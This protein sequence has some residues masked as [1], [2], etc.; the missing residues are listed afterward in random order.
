LR[1]QTIM[2]VRTLLLEN[3][4]HAF[5]AF[6][7][8]TLQTKV[9]LEWVLRLLFERSGTQMETA[10]QVVYWVNTAGLSL[11]YRRLLAEVAGGLG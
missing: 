2:T 1:K 6:L 9:S 7:L 3:A 8:A 4:L 11:P 5:M 10:A